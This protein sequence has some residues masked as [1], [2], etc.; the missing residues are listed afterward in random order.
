MTA[1]PYRVY[2]RPRMG[3]LLALS[4]AAPG[5]VADRVAGGAFALAATLERAMTRFD[6]SSALNRLNRAAGRPV[7]VP[8]E[9]ARV[10]RTARRLARLTDGA[11]DPTVAPVL[12]L[13]RRAAAHGRPP[14]DAAVGRARGL[15][16]WRAL[17]VR[18]PRAGLRRRGMALD[19][20]AIGK[21]WAVDRIARVLARVEGLAGVV[22]FGESTLAAVGRPAG[23][24]RV[25]LR[26][27]A[28]GFV[29][30]F[31]L[32]GGA[33]STSG[34]FGRAWRIGGR[35]IGHVIDPRSGRPLTE[36]AQ[37]TVLAPSAT[38]AEALSTALLVSGRAAIR[39][40]ARRLGAEACWID[41]EGVLATPGFQLHPLRDRR[42]A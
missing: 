12:D 9:L 3:T 38:V 42:T 39:P 13:W 24:R 16:G 17:T 5:P 31:E 1:P 22:N 32:P 30:W 7:G 35:T 23:G 19:L 8:G 11:F 41:G 20:G 25:L 4:I 21:G 18:G 33:C 28:A 34:S 26:H 27:P 37:V 15:V 6:G 14:A 10:L 29:G 2:V 36:A 40:L